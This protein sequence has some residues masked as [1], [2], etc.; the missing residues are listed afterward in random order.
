M[1]REYFSC[2]AQQ[3]FQN[4]IKIRIAHLILFQLPE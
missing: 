2:K 1:S 4:L 3:K